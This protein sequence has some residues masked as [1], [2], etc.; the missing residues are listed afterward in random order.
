MA[1]EAAERFRGVASRAI[2]LCFPFSF[3]IQSTRP[4]CLQMS[5][6]RCR[7]WA[8]VPVARANWPA[9][10]DSGRSPPNRTV[11]PRSRADVNALAVILPAASIRKRALR[12]Y[13]VH[14][15]TA[16][17]RESEPAHRDLAN[18]SA[19]AS[20]LHG[21]LPALRL[22]RPINVALRRHG[23]ATIPHHLTLRT[24]IGILL[25]IVLKLVLG[26]VPVGLVAAIDDRD[27]GLN[28]LL[29]QPS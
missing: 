15:S 28:L 16:C 7:G 11:R 3:P 9:V 2:S 18:R 23:Q 22:C 26:E 27:V 21:A 12:P 19:G 1:K 4:S 8:H 29:Q 20:F 14:V 5:F 13:S 6:M 17:R 24:T 25:R 10:S